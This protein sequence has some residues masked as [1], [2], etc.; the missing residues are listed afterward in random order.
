[1]R[2]LLARL[3]IVGLVGVALTAC[4]TQNGSSL[5]VGA[6]PNG[7]GGGNTNVSNQAP[8]NG[9]VP[10]KLI[11]GGASG[12]ATGFNVHVTD[13]ISATPALPE[14]PVCAAVSTVVGVDVAG[15]H[16]IAYTSNSVA[17]QIIKVAPTPNLTFSGGLPG[18]IMPI[19]YGAV[20]FYATPPAGSTLSL[21]ITGGSGPGFDWRGTCTTRATGGTPSTRYLCPIPAYNATITQQFANPVAVPGGS[22]VP[23]PTSNVY[24]VVKNPAAVAPGTAQ[25]LVLDY[26]FAEQGAL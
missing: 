23:S 14:D 10:C 2:S 25:T 22:F 16:S 5:T 21:E 8:P 9:T 19:D 12:A 6:L 15:Q 3:A 4:G 24:V 7:A 20:V 18:Q 1:M 13:T 17:Q 11:D 26:M